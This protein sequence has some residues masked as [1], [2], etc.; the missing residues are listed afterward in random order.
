[1]TIIIALAHEDGVTIGSDSFG[2]CG[3]TLIYRN[4]MKWAINQ[5]EQYGLSVAIAGD[6]DIWH[7]VRELAVE[8]NDPWAYCE[9]LR[10]R[11][12]KEGWEPQSHE[13]S[14]P[15]WNLNMILTNGELVWDVG[16]AIYPSEMDFG[17]P[18]AI[19]TGQEYAL[20]AMNA[21]QY[22]LKQHVLRHIKK[23]TDASMVVV[24]DG[25]A[26][27]IHYDT[28]CGGAPWIQTIT[29]KEKA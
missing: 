9:E 20:G 10:R 7:V 26:A 12:R 14:M 24:T 19:G 28:K 5:G 22:A 27:A 17:A 8:F 13:G 18:S 2:F 15:T 16:G 6:A 11:F 29:K 1:M 25:L 21:T 4:E 23:G 3:D